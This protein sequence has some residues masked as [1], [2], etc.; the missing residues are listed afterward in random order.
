MAR[1]RFYV[2]VGAACAIFGAVDVVQAAR[3]I[4][5]GDF[6]GVAVAVVGAAGGM[7]AFVLARA[8]ARAE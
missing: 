6:V 7:L 8:E 4:A 2:A 5:R 1:R 3:A